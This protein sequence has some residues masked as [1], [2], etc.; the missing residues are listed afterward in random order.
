MVNAWLHLMRAVLYGH[1]ILLARR[2]RL[3]SSTWTS[4]E[5]TRVLS[6][7]PHLAQLRRPRSCAMRESSAGFLSGATAIRRAL[8]IIRPDHTASSIASWETSG[9]YL[10][11]HQ[12]HISGRVAFLTGPAAVSYAESLIAFVEQY[13]LGE[14]VGSPTAGTNG[15]LAEVTAPSGCRT[16]FSGRRVAHHEPRASEAIG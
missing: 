13:H 7:E 15:D 3:S 1:S 4:P 9:W 12:P 14:I 8:H 6:R 10:P 5:C 16:A 2:Q 11:V